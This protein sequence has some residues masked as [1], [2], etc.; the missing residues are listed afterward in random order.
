MNGFISKTLVALGLGGGIVAL[1]GCDKYL[2]CVD[3][4]YPQR[5]EYQAR[6]EVQA[7]FDP[8][9]NNGHVL[10]QTIWN[11]HFEAGTDKLTPGGLEHL[12]YIARRRPSPDP[13]VWLQTAQDVAYDPAAPDKF[14]QARNSLDKKRIA[15]IEKFLTADTA[16]RPVKFVVSLHDPAEVGM[17]AI[18]AD[19]AVQQMYNGYRGN[20]PVTAGAGNISATGGAGAMGGSNTGGGSGGGSGGGNR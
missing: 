2:S 16:G 14:V 11:H 7:C 5:Y 9:V 18:P 1:G 13:M 3:V 15:A 20:L 4:C 6:Q 12:A 10:D 17:H 19:R 8:Q